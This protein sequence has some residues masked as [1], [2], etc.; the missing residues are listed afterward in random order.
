MNWD[1]VSKIVS[2]AAPLVGTLIGGPA[3][4][5]I[6]ALVASTLGTEPTEESILKELQMNPDALLKVKELEI[7]NKEK[8]E[9]L[10]VTKFQAETADRQDA[11]LNNKHSKMPAVVV[12]MLTLMVFLY[13]LGLFFFE[14]IEG[15]REMLYYFGGQLLTL[16]AASIYFWVGTSRSSSEKSMFDRLKTLK[17]T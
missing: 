8:L 7:R 6:G 13:G 5:T 12:I 10:A 4:G 3:G 15:N 1:K 16:W 14:P 11:R 9:E 2:K 17:S